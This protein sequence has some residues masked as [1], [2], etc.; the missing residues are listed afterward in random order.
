MESKRCDVC[1]KYVTSCSILEGFECCKCCHIT[2]CQY[3]CCPPE[4]KL[5]DGSEINPHDHFILLDLCDELNVMRNACDRVLDHDVS[6]FLAEEVMSAR[7]SLLDA[8]V[9]IDSD[10]SMSETGKRLA[11]KRIK[12][13]F[14][15]YNQACFLLLASQDS[16]YRRKS[17]YGYIKHHLKRFSVKSICKSK[18]LTEKEK[19]MLIKLKNN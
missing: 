11:R 2:D 16:S 6:K 3:D 14:K 18:F 9:M 7:D 10:A 13:A 17:I 1:N 15:F 19:T 4:E 8:R 5:I 12:L